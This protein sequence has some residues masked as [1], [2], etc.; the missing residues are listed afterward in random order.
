[1]IVKRSR[2]LACAVGIGVVGAAYSPNANAAIWSKAMTAEVWKQVMGAGMSIFVKEAIWD[3]AKG[4]W[5]RPGQIIAQATSVKRDQAYGFHSEYYADGSQGTPFMRTFVSVRLTHD[6]GVSTP[7]N[8]AGPYSLM[9]RNWRFHHVLDQSTGAEYFREGSGPSIPYGAVDATGWDVPFYA[10]FGTY[11]NANGDQGL[12]ATPPNRF[13]TVTVEYKLSDLAINPV[14]GTIVST[15]RGRIERRTTRLDS[16]G[17]PAPGLVDLLEYKTEFDTAPVALGAVRRY[18]ALEFNFDSLPS[19]SG[20]WEPFW[21]PTAGEILE[22]GRLLAEHL[23]N[24]A[25]WVVRMEKL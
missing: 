17:T 24:S 5:T 15:P 4:L 2:R 22:R 3:P 16:I 7:P 19:D 21:S 10:V 9:D 8:A 11:S 25:Q 1:M 14:N 18:W 23:S 13:Y 20:L 6:S 12:R